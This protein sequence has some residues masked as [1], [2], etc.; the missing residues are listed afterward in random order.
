MLLNACMNVHNILYV[1]Y[2]YM[3]YMIDI[4]TDSRDYTNYHPKFQVPKME[5]LTYVSCMDTAYVRE[6]PHP[7]KQPAISYR[8]P[9]F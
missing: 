2:M 7:P 3:M 8:P 1:C 5:V 9:P 4:R 6:F